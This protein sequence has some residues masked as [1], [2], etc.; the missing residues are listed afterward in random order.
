MPSDPTTPPRNHDQGLPPRTG[1][2]IES[3]VPPKQDRKEQR[4]YTPL[5]EEETYERES[6][7]RQRK[8]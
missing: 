2:A 5:P 7:T 3:T 6:P 1:E 8:D 4:E